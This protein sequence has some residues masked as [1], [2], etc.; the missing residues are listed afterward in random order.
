M[1]L[2]HDMLRRYN[3]LQ[4]QRRRTSRAY[5]ADNNALAT[6]LHNAST[7]QMLFH[8]KTHRVPPKNS[9]TKRTTRH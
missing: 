1:E 7:E 9:R 4:E 2:L 3:H 5:H 8:A 6:T